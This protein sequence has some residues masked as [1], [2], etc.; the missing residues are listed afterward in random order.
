MNLARRQFLYLV[1]GAVAVPAVSTVALALSYPT[2]PIRVMVG[3]SPGGAPD[4]VARLMG[5]GLSEQFGQQIVVENRPGAGNTI[6]MES[7]AKAS[8]DGYTLALVGT[9]AATSATLYQ[10]L[11]Y[12][13]IRDLAPVAGLVRGPLVMVVDPAFPAKTIP[14][15][16]AYAKGN[17]TT[18]NMASAGTGTGPHVAGELF[19]MMSGSNMIH[20]PYRGGPAALTAVLGGQVQVY[21]VAASSSIENIKA[22]KL[23]A[24]AVT[25][26]TRWEGLPDVPALD[27][28]LPGYEASIWFGIGAPKNTPAESID[29]LNKEINT[30]LSDPQT[31]ARLAALGST[32]MPMTPAEFGRLVAEETEKWAKVIKFS[33]AK[34]E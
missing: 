21:F 29:K 19:N 8:P 2:R 23:R 17:P 11:N 4:I 26:A 20:V 15:F 24:L 16:I 31:R 13:L 14:E 30:G 6:A 28:F 25:T 34:V 9:S 10:N 1:A 33:G 5:K 27:E 7:V 12:D 18:I 22:G 32:P 3:D